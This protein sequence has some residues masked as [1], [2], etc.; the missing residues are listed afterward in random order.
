MG[1]TST[2][3]PMRASAA[4]APFAREREAGASSAN[5]DDAAV[6]R[7]FSMLMQERRIRWCEAHSVWLV[8]V[9]HRHV[10]SR[11][12]FDDAIRAAKQACEG[13]GRSV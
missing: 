1:A 10:A 11:A 7:W 8:S 5:A 13:T 2:G 3:Q 4:T 9:D 12:S 6:W